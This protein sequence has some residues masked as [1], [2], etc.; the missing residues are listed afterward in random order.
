MRNMFE[1][2]RD[3]LVWLEDKFI[4]YNQL[5]R[6]IAVRKE[7]LKTRE[8]DSNT[9]G[10]K[11]NIVGN[12]IE[13]QIVKEQSDD[14]IITRQKW[15]RAIASVY[16]T[17]NDEVKSVITR[18]YWSSENYLTWEDIGKDHCMSKSQI[19]RLR[20]GILEKFA[21]LIGYI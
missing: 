6:E 4:R 13:S 21:K 19:Y 11:T 8:E 16:D 15:K 7:E 3:D 18:K 14:F 20:Y 12:P 5:D 17:S 9:G 2:T 1:L 10:G